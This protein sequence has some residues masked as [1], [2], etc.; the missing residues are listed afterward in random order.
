[1]IRNTFAGL[2]LASALAVPALAQDAPTVKSIDVTLDMAAVQNAQAAAYWGTLEADLEG[3]ILARVQPQV[4]DDGVDISIDISE[5]ELSNGFQEVVGIADTRLIGSV[6]M[7][8][9]TDN[10]RFDAY[11]LTVDVNAATPLLPEGFVMATATVDTKEYY[12]AM[13]TA[14]ANG[15]VKRLK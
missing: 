3:A 15:V 14:F 8:H 5:V 9:L 2:F 1:M 4:A 6:K 12:D 7:T 10:S 11:E 13:I